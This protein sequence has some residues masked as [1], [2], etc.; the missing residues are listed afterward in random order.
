MKINSTSMT[1]LCSALVTAGILGGCTTVGQQ[2]RDNA[3][4][5]IKQAE[6]AFGLTQEAPRQ[7][8]VVDSYDFYVS[9]KAIRVRDDAGLLPPVF[10]LPMSLTINPRAS[11]RDIGQQVARA[12]SI[13]VSFAHDV[14]TEA[15]Q[16]SMNAGLQLNAPLKDV[17]D[18]IA[19]QNNVSWRYRDG[20]VEF[21]RVETRVFQVYAPPGSSEATTTLSN[22]NSAA[23][24]GNNQ[25]TSSNGQDY[26]QVSKV[27]FWGSTEQDIKQMLSPNRGKV[28]ISQSLGAVT[29]TDTPVVLNSIDAYIKQINFLRS[30]NISIAVQVYAVET[31]AGEAF[32][33]RLTT[34]YEKLGEYGLKLIS[35]TSG[36]IENS[37]SVSASVTNERSRFLGSGAFMQALNSIG[38]ASEVDNFSIVTV[39][40]EP[41]PLNSLVNEGY[42]A[43]VSVQQPSYVGG[44][45]TQSLEPGI[46]TYGASGMLTPKLI[47]GTDMQ[48]RVALDLSSKLGLR[49]VTSTDGGASIQIAETGSRSFAN[50]FNIKTGQTLIIGL[51]TAQNTFSGSSMIDPDKASSVFAGGARSSKQTTRTLVFAITPSVT[52]SN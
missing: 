50:T 14:E 44:T 11:M 38:S 9:T 4:R 15:S 46:I 40:G 10:R 49:K 47:N 8:R 31:N 29:V 25:S 34:V 52:T 26:K 12:A 28:V 35:P 2:V 16:P 17:L 18:N 43:K 37:G 1:R 20:A 30:R 45:P 36:V 32:D 23:G 21:Y 42:L 7:P 6:T 24:T 5:D 27:D 39:T 48:L 19:R 41:A 22:K 3:N 33:L 51:Q 13:S